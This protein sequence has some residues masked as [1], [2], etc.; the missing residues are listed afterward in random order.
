MII[1]IKNVIG[2]DVCRDGGTLVAQYE[3]YRGRK[4]CL[5]FPVDHK[6]IVEDGKFIDLEF[7]GYKSPVLTTYKPDFYKSPVTGI[8]SPKTSESKRDV[9]WSYACKVLSKLKPL[10]AKANLEREDIYQ[11][12]VEVAGNGGARKNS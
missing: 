10:V 4:Y 7:V 6:A 12:M 1:L 2:F 8:E 5:D 3:G 11:K 9:S